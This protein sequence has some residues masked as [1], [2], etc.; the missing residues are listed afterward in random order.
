M[1]QASGVEGEQVYLLLEDH[2]VT[3]SAFLDMVNSLLSSGEVPGLYKIEELESIASPLKDIAAQEGFVGSATAYFFERVHKNLHVILV[4][5]FT[6]PL[7][8]L[9]CES[10]PAL[11]KECCVMWLPGWSSTSMRTIPHLLLNRAEKEEGDSRH[12]STVTSGRRRSSVNDN[13]IDNFVRIHEQVSEK[14]TTPLRYTFFIHTYIHIYRCKKVD[15]QQ[16]QQRLQAGVS[17]LTE[18]RQV[19]DALKSQAAVQEQKLAEKQEKANSALQMI[20]ETMRNANTHKVEMESLK[21]RTERENIQLMERTF[22]ARRIN[23]ESR[24]AV[25]KLMTERKESFDPKNARRA[26]VAAAP[27]AAWVIANVKYSYVL[28]KIRPLEREQSKLHQ[29]LKLAEDQIGKLSVGLTDV[30]KTVTELKNQLNTY[31]KEAAELEI[32]LNKAQETIN[33]AEAI[34]FK[35]YLRA[36]SDEHEERVFQIQNMPENH[37]LPLSSVIKSGHLTSILILILILKFGKVLIVQEVDGIDP[38]LFPILRGDFINQGPR[39]V[40]QVGDKLIDYND[41]FQLF[42]TTRNPEPEIPPDAAAIITFVNFTTTWAGLTG[43]KP[44][45]EQ[46]RS[47]LL[48]QEEEFKLKLDQ[49]QEILLQELANAQGDILQNKDLLASLNEAKASSAAVYESLSESSRLQAELNQE[50]DSY[51]P[52]AEFGSTLYFVIMD[53]GKLNN[54]YQFSAASFMRLFEKALCG[55]KEDEPSDL[56]TKGYQKRLQHIVYQYIPEDEWNVFTGQAVSDV[57][58]ESSKVNENLPSWIDE[59][60]AFDVFVLKSGLPNLY[61]ELMLEDKASWS[62]FARS[63]ECENNFPVQLARKLTPFQQVLVIQALRP[64]RLYSALVQFALQTLGLHDLSPPALSLKQLLPETLSMEPVLLVISPGAD[65]SEE[66]R[67]LAQLTVGDQHYFEVAMGQ[68]Q[69]TV[70]LDHLCAAARQGDWLCLK[71]LHLMTYGY[72][73]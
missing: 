50:C 5:D 57:K 14:L 41:S 17:K 42:L 9:T 56:K 34:L 23:P 8:T 37:L 13:L 63:G 65:P 73:H 3:D 58:I 20:T 70:A 30:D 12:S 28:E 6:N 31:T 1:M 11:Y 26:S 45:L 22:D 16:R 33:A 44:E 40:V 60:R 10:N 59:E 53:L 67:A 61:T 43:Q 69:K 4:M 38:V 54:M 68:G 71:N 21:D 27:L 62:S 19:V 49:L 72:Q 66:L 46:R 32:H 51:R 7:F 52:L 55:P 15:I 47:E 64:D 48:K 2:Q 29:N 24:Q 25:E 36:V 39:K 35:L 18:A